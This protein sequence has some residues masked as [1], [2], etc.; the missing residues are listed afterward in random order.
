[1]RHYRPGRG[2]LVVP[3]EGVEPTYLFFIIHLYLTFYA[4]IQISLH[5]CFHI[6]LAFSPPLCYN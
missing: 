6:Y 4:V 3:E 5:T 2:L 1:M